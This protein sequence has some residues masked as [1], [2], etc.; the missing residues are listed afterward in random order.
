MQLVRGRGLSDR[1][2]EGT[3]RIAVV[4]EAMAR[5]RFNGDA[6]GHR[7]TL[8]YAGERDRPFTVVG[9]VR[10]AKYNSLRETR[11]KPML[12]A[13]L[14]QAPFRI[15][16]VALR[17]EPGA[18]AAVLRE[19]EAVL[20]GTNGDLMVRRTTMLAAEVDQTMVRERL[21]MRIVIGR[22]GGRGP[23]RGDRSVWHAQLRGA[24]PLPRNRRAHG[25]RRRSRGRAAPGAPRCPYP[26]SC[27]R[28][29][30]YAAGD[31]SWIRPRPILFGVT[32]VDPGTIIACGAFM[33]IVALGRRLS[34]GTSGRDRRP[35]HRAALGMSVI[36][37]RREPAH[38]V[39]LLPDRS[40][41]QK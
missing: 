17:T 11:T 15:S 39:E 8:D 18:E 14:A 35:S 9:I 26:R 40:R 23:P 3:E 4:N 34:A 19:A 30:R 29:R 16:S 31:W 21:L 32:P 24:A 5:M 28:R 22:C 38:P 41:C 27:R 25:V 2:R 36:G 33:T 13:A 37:I 12:W 7:L 1:D 6:L 20:K 10:D